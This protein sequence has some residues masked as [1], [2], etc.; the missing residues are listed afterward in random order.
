[1]KKEAVHLAVEMKQKEREYRQGS[2]K[3]IAHKESL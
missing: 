2:E 3:H 1:M